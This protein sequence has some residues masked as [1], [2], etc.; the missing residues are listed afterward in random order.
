[1]DAIR[2]RNKSTG[3]L[4]Y[5]LAHGGTVMLEGNK[6]LSTK[7][8]EIDSAIATKVTEQWVN[9]R[10]DELLGLTGTD[11]DTIINKFNEIVAFLATYTESD[12]LAALMSG[13][14]T[15]LNGK[16]G[17]L[18]LSTG[19]RY[20]QAIDASLVGKTIF[21]SGNI[22]CKVYASD[23]SLLIAYWRDAQIERLEPAGI[24]YYEKLSGATSYSYSETI[25]WANATD[26]QKSSLG[27]MTAAQTAAINSG[28]TSAILQGLINRQDILF[29]EIGSNAATFIAIST[30]FTEG[31]LLVGMDSAGANYSLVGKDN[32]NFVFAKT[33]DG[34][35]TTSYTLNRTTG[36]GQATTFTAAP[37][38]DL[39]GYEFDT[40]HTE[41]NNGVVTI[42]AGAEEQPNPG[43]PNDE[44]DE[45]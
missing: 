26:F 2:G 4:V 42:V 3:Q 18:D 44:F 35:I 20:Q 37:L 41:T 30:A 23:T 8:G 31:K 32:N 22:P 16:V 36:W 39:G 24:Y 27:F 34:G 15:Q 10:I 40:V 5:F 45:P 13:M 38:A 1:M 21:L 25:T 33:D 11:S 43:R 29:F 12:S 28:I 9:N 17:F 7:L 14:Q 6:L 19:N